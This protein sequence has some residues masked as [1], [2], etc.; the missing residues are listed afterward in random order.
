MLR[1]TSIIYSMTATALAGSAVVAALATG[2]VT[3]TAIV[4]AAAIGAV[5]ALPVSYLIAKSLSGN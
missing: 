1:L 5:A 2:N 3:A 4:V